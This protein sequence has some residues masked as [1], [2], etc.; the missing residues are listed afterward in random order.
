MPNP[1]TAQDVADRWRPFSDSAEQDRAAVLLD[2]AWSLLVGE[3]T[4]VEARLEAEPPTL[5][6][7]I[8]V[9]VLVRA[10]V[11]VLRNPNALRQVSLQDYSETHAGGGGE[12]YIDQ[13]DID[14]LTPDTAGSAAFTIVPYGRPGRGY[15]CS[16]ADCCC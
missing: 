9:M 7:R 6:S 10:V 8:V 12:L 15:C 14:L 4:D 11:R 1:A 2:D 16:D 3:V 13:A 5:D